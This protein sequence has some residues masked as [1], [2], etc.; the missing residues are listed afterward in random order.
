MDRFAYESG[1][2]PTVSTETVST[3][4]AMVDGEG[5][6]ITTIDIGSA[7]LHSD[8]HEFVAVYIALHLAKHACEVDHR[9]RKVVD[10]RGRVLE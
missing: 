6:K 9:M 3:Q 8:M 4:L 10:S 2:S 5:M 1:S 7:Y